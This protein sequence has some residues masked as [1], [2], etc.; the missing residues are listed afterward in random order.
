MNNFDLDVFDKYYL[1]NFIEEHMI[2]LIEQKRG[3]SNNDKIDTQLE[4]FSKLLYLLKTY[5]ASEHKPKYEFDVENIGEISDGSH[6]FNELYM[7]RTMLFAT[8]CNTYKNDAWKSWKHNH[9]ENFPMYEDYFIV[10]VNTPEGQY[11][12]HCHK[13]WWDKFEVPELEEAP[14]F[15]GHQPDD[16]DRLLSLIKKEDE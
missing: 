14:A 16:V 7:H 12:Y 13:D 9:E 4:I 15:D 3:S 6:T 10:G 2:G 8:I 1:I 5:R 11:S